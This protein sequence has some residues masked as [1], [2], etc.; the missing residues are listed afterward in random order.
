MRKK[1]RSI[2]PPV[3]QSASAGSVEYSS[4]VPTLLEHFATILPRLRDNAAVPTWPPDVFALVASFFHRTGAYCELLRSWPPDKSPGKDPVEVWQKQTREIGEDWVKSWVAKE[5]APRAI[6]DIWT[7]VTLDFQK[8]LQAITK[9]CEACS[10]LYWLLA[11]ADEASREVGIPPYSVTGKKDPIEE[12]FRFYAEGLLQR[13]LPGS[14]VCREVHPLRARVLPKMHTPATGLGVRSLSLYL[15]FCP[16]T[17]VTP[18]WIIAPF[19]TNPSLNLLLVPWPLEV[20]PAQFDMAQPADGEPA[21]N[22]FTFAHRRKGTDVVRLVQQLIARAE[23]IVGT[24]DGIV[25]PELA[26]TPPEHERMREAMEGRRF[27]I[28]GVGSRSE[29]GQMGSNQVCLDLPAA[30]PF[31]QNKHHRWKLDQPQI[32]QYGLG[33]KLYPAVSWWEHIPLGDR[34][35]LFAALLPWLVMSFLV[36]ED[37]ARPDPVADLVRCVG[38]NLVVAVL[39]DGPQLKDRWPGRYATVLADDPGCSVLT[40]TNV[41]M[42]DL[43]RP[44]SGPRRGRVIGLWKDAI[45]RTAT[46]IEL[47]AGADAMLLSLSVILREEKT[48]DGRTDGGWAGYP[49]LSGLHPIS[50]GAPPRIRKAA[51]SVKKSGRGR[52]GKS[53]TTQ[54]A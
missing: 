1:S 43:S 7:S 31:Y 29:V 14:S 47:P 39:M 15:T 54:Q 27:L 25:L 5:D 24:V 23:E 28:T 2:Q 13:P 41:G 10:R 37:L 22:Y 4:D 6:H 20:V 11:A 34:R 40:L 38:P 32:A 45:S 8:S 26:L 46:E 53:R 36:C 44:S 33:S 30:V 9:D 16:S 51:E 52:N 19:G 49:Q 42:T 50:V 17:E 21:W 35:V 3:A 18:E 12:E 48:A